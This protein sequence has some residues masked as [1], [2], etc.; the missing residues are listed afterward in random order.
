[1]IEVKD[2]VK[3]YSNV[4]AVNGLNFTVKP[5]E[6]FGLIGPNGAGKSTCI[7]MIMNII[8][9]DS[10]E[11][12]IDGSPMTEKDKER[13]GYLPEER[14]LYRKVKVMEMLKYLGQLKGLDGSSA[15]GRAL[16]WLKKFNLESWAQRKIEELSKGM[17]QKVQFIGT[18]IHEPRIIL[19]DEPFA[20]LDPASQD[21]LLKILLELRDEGRTIIFSTHIMDHAEKICEKILLINNGM[22]VASGKLAE[23]K[24]S[25]GSA[26]TRVEY[27]GDAAFVKELPFVRDLRSF[28]R[29]MEVELEN[30]DASDDLYKA[31]AGRIKVRRFELL[32]PSL[33]SIFLKLTADAT[34]GKNNE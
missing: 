4:K 2:A 18:I 19:F 17:A 26:V 16:Y 24:A 14:G 9:P 31:L 34:K 13:I 23:L 25:H 20:G 7:R 28:P 8:S 22:E 6:I 3:T 27:D 29:L 21:L 1:M 32:E 30:M 11:V 12:F 10:G 5:G 15:E 33:H